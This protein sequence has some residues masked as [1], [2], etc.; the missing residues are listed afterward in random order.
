MRVYWFPLFPLVFTA[1]FVSFALLSILSAL[2]TAEMGFFVPKIKPCSI[3]TS[4]TLLALK[5]LRRGLPRP[6]VP[7]RGFVI[8]ASYAFFGIVRLTLAQR[9]NLGII[10]S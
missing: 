1:I 10:G 7:Q 3:I 5:S 2:L 8:L 6:A 9:S 4:R